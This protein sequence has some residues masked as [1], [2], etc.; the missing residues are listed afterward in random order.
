MSE[1]LFV[2]EQEADGGYVARAH[3]HAIFAQADTEAE[4]QAAVRDA[5]QCHFEPGHGPALIRLHI[6]RDV[7][8]AA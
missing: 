4:L 3:G 6:V 1:L 7:L 8:M 2:A 5:V